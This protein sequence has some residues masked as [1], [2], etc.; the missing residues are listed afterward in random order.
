MQRL[1]G[2]AEH[3]PFER[4]AMAFLVGY[5]ASSARAYLAD[6][7]A[8]AAAC[9]QMGTHPFD[10]RRHHVDA[11]VRVLSA[12]PLPRTNKPM[13]PASIARRLSA[14]SAFYDYGI[15]VDVLDF[16]PVANVR[17]PKVSE[18]SSTVGLSAD[19]TP[20]VSV[21]INLSLAGGWMLPVRRVDPNE[22]RFGRYRRAR[23]GSRQ[24]AGASSIHCAPTCLA[25]DPD[26]DLRG[27]RRLPE[28]GLPLSADRPERS[29]DHHRQVTTALLGAVGCSPVSVAYLSSPEW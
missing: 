11:W 1:P 12:D 9:A 27:V 14:V 25:A 26:Q 2:S 3:D 23:A 17:R 21:V 24:S 18:D 8:W 28:A 6:L 10:A 19:R 5:T 29:D 13:A 15:S 20:A 22:P 7:K 4:L 16:S